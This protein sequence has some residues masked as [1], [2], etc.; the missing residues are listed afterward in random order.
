VQICSVCSMGA[1]YSFCSV[2]AFLTIF[3]KTIENM[4]ITYQT[5]NIYTHTYTRSSKKKA[6]ILNYCNYVNYYLKII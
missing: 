5:T 4:G 1:G 3:F 6:T 2:F